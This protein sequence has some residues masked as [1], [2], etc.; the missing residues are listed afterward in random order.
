MIIYKVTNLVNGMV[1]IGKTKRSLETRWK[2]HC[3]DMNS[4][5]AC[6]K[7]QQAI[8]EFGAEN[9]KIEQIDCAATKEEADAKEVYWIQFYHATED[10]YNTSP[11]GKAGGNYRKVMVVETGQTFN[12]MVD[13][14]KTFGVSVGSIAQAVKNPTW[15][16]CGL[17][18]KKADI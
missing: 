18:W 3:R 2:Q 17:H 15:K 6:F 12:S 10:G 9:F 1:Y 4:R 5:I 11:G 14:A 16:C 7:L 13:A 8:K